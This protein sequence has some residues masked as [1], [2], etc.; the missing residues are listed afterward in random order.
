MRQCERPFVSGPDNTWVPPGTRP[1]LQL[2]LIGGA[3]ETMAPGSA[4]L[5]VVTPS[6]IITQ[7]HVHSAHPGASLATRK[8]YCNISN[9]IIILAR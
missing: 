4:I 3:R 1:N 5:L 7:G 6:G 9:G 8:P 2:E